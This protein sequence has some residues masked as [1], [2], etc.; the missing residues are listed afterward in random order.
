MGKEGLKGINCAALSVSTECS[1]R[2]RRWRYLSML[3]L[4]N[5][6]FLDAFLGSRLS[7]LL[8]SLVTMLCVHLYRNLVK[9]CH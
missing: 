4:L 5:S 9:K 1:G 3:N 7:H 6:G 8:H 2:A